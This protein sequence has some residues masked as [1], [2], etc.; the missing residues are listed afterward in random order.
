VNTTA[1]PKR[2]TPGLSW[3]S[4]SSPA[5]DKWLPGIC[6]GY[7]VGWTYA[8]IAFWIGA[9][10]AVVGL[11]GGAFGGA[12]SELA[13]TFHIA[14][15]V[16]FGAAVIGLFVGAFSGL[17]FIYVE[18]Y[19]NI[20]NIIGGIVSGLA[21]S[22]FTLWLIVHYEPQLLRLRG[23]REL[24]RREKRLIDPIAGEI[25]ERMGIAG[26]TPIFYVSDS[27]QPAAWTHANSIV[28]AQ[29]LLGSY[30]DSENPPVPD[31]PP[32]AFAAVI[33][34]EISHWARADGVGIRAV[35][36]CCW[37]IVAV[38]NFACILGRNP[39][40]KFTALG[41]ILFWPAWVSINVVVIPMLTN[42]MRQA[43]YEADARTASLG[44]EYRAGLRTALLEF[45]DWEAPR[46]GWEDVLHATHP[47]IELRQQQ[48]EAGASTPFHE[49][50]AKMSSYVELNSSTF[51]S[52]RVPDP[53]VLDVGQSLYLA[54]KE[55]NQ[56]LVKMR[57]ELFNIAALN[58]LRK[59]EAAILR[60][61]SVD[62]DESLENIQARI[63]TLAA[64]PSMPVTVT[65]KGN[66]I[67]DGRANSADPY[68]DIGSSTLGTLRVVDPA[69]L[70][71]GN[72]LVNAHKEGNPEAVK[73]REGLF[74]VV[75]LDW[76]RKIE[77]ALQRGEA[78]DVDESLENIQARIAG[79]EA[80]STKP[81]HLTWSGGDIANNKPTKWWRRKS[82]EQTG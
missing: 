64:N 51:G 45:Q 79:A 66:V 61:D 36:A 35:W 69:V 11:I 19:H 70:D 62:V 46:T 55:G 63:A 3:R 44:D 22:L 6:G 26:L 81:L 68:I 60:G 27:K 59:V 75:L 24:S 2:D 13:N 74:N 39:N 82:A 12:T 18:F 15:G 5:F 57:E 65:K 9:I 10:F 43:E 7:L 58:W 78:V 67:S 53:A 73:V 71:A 31:M 21:V 72:L 56:E 4:L 28:L 20:F 23:Y 48:L 17:V 38:Y 77:A 34:H 76:L 49:T 30:D 54:H 42:A 40:R 47:P 52:L 32:H 41:W 16:G 14:E 8:P 37:P 25:L 29:G 50:E 1:P 80:D 33:A